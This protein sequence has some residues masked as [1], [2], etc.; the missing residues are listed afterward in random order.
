MGE[1]A[2]MEA[3]MGTYEAEVALK[4]QKERSKHQQEMEALLHRA[5]RGRD[6]LTATRGLDMERRQQRFKNVMAE[7]HN[8]Q[9]L[10]HV[11]LQHFLEQKTIA[12]KRPNVAV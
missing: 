5:A 4:E 12:G 2:E 3:T 10:E 7:L 9:R 11:Q 8:L 1:N 6:E